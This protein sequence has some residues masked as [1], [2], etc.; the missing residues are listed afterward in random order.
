MKRLLKPPTEKLKTKIRKLLAHNSLITHKSGKIKVG[1]KTL[2]SYSPTSIK[3]S[4]YR[5]YPSKVENI[6]EEDFEV[7]FPLTDENLSL[8]GS[9][10]SNPPIGAKVIIDLFRKS[11]KPEIRE[12]IIGTTENIIN[13]FSLSVT[14]DF[15][16]T[17][18]RINKEESKDKTIR[19]NNR[20]RP[21]LES[22]FSITPNSQSISRDYSLLLEEVIASGQ[23]TQQDII[24]LTNRLNQGNSINFVVKRQITKQAE[25]LIE[26]IQAILDEGKINT[27]KAKELGNRH[28]GFSQISITGPE[29]LMEKILTKYGKY[30]LFGVPVLLNTDKYVVH[31]GNLTRSQF[32]IILINHLSDIEVVELK[33]P[34]TTVLDY[35]KNRGKFYA[36]K[37]LSIAVSQAERYISAVYRDNDEDYKINNQKIKDFL[38][39]QIGGSMTIEICRPKALI[40]LGSFL[41]IAPDYNSLDEETKR[42]ISNATYT[43]NYLQAYKEIK[44]SY[45]NIHILTYSELVENARTRLITDE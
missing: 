43:T 45:K 12:V 25:W 40:I 22:F 8:L 29:H 31:S 34:D 26:K 7:H 37:E 17:V 4:V 11:G 27:K 1:S 15:Y 30:T 9:N 33:R 16:E 41:T 6:V 18:L 42:K 13:G 2:F 38:N 24:E 23:I 21:F 3:Y 20:V 32:D 28:F 19:F 10:I 14:K 36:S 5:Y 39:S 44:D 35:D